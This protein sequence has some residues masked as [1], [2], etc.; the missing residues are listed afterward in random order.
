MRTKPI[1]DMDLAVCILFYEKLNQTIE[2]IQSFLPSGVN[3]YVLN[4]GSSSASRKVLGEFCDNYEQVKLFDSDT[5]LG[6]SRGRNYLITHTNEEWMFF[7][8]ND[9]VVKTPDWLQKISKHISL[10]NEIEVFIAR[11]FETQTNAYS[12]Y[13]P[14]TIVGDKVIRTG[15][16]TDG[17]TNR[18]PGGASFIN[19]KLFGRLGLYDDKLF[20]T[21]EYEFSIRGIRLGEP[22]KAKQIYDIELDHDHRQ[23]KKS[24]D[25]KGVLVR[26]DLNLVK[27]SLNRIIEKHNLIL[28][29]DWESWSDETAKKM[30]KNNNQTSKTNM[31]QYLTDKAKEMRGQREKRFLSFASFVLPYRI[32][33]ILNRTFY[34]TPPRCI[35]HCCSL[36]MTH[37]SN[38]N[39]PKY[40]R[41]ISEVKKS[42][43]MTLA[44]VQKLLSLYPAID[45]FTVTGIGEPTLCPNFVDI[46]NFLKK[47]KNF[48]GIITDGMNLDKLLEPSYEPNYIS[49]SLY[50]Y[51][52]KSYLDNTGIDA[53]D[54]VIETFS[55]S[56]SR[57]KNV[58]F[59]FILN[60]TNYKDLDNVLSLCDNLK[61]E[62]IH[63]I[64]HLI[65][66]AGNPDEV[67]KI[68][69][70][71]DTHII[72]YI[73]DTCMG[74]DY[75]RVKPVYLD[76][77]NP[78]FNCKSYD[79]KINVDGDGNI[80]GCQRQIPPDSSFGNIFID[81]DPYNSSEMRKS[82]N[83][84]RE[85]SYA[86]DECCFCF[87]N[88]N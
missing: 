41:S 59:S 14:F 47:K 16:I 55:K 11:L 85:N 31:G 24:E 79:Y 8:D 7:V 35:P 43:D 80:G 51:D 29:G 50:G 72:D 23:A 15:K 12:E 64:N 5:N 60:R 62:F 32:K 20:V 22:V 61:P 69:T 70:V 9:I 34:Q 56:K 33:K 78:K 81:K 45:A 52:N 82:R 17:L 87:A 88:W 19:R 73:N 30:L 2:C 53:F 18:F 27:A 76:L 25:R 66:D 40:F 4:N 86:H 58:G 77:D 48:I 28:E 83:L 6:P 26:Y 84:M 57:F 49:I 44:T 38:F 46:V 10:H 75:I 37:N 71:K 74:R 36:Y 68:I 67:R 65:Y 13:P 21:E 54:T 39:H 63:L 1:T 42:R 3:I